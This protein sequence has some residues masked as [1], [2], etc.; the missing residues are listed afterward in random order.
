MPN[1]VSKI[2]KVAELEAEFWKQ[3]SDPESKRQ[4]WYIATE[5]VKSQIAWLEY[6]P[7]AEL[8]DAEVE[9]L[10]L[11]L[12]RAYVALRRLTARYID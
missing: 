4:S 10:T 3:I 11:A 9:N 6:V 8:T 2:P 1:P 12:K 7:E 5:M